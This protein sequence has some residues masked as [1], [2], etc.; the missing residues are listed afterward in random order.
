MI[1]DEKTTQCDEC[2]GAG[3]YCEK[4]GQ[5]PDNCDCEG[6][7]FVDCE[8]CNGDGFVEIEEI[9]DEDEEED[10]D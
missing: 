8:P 10:S 6:E 2:D 7:N 3:Q 1:D 5:V 9:E 4:C